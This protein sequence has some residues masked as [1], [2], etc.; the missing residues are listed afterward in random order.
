[1]VWGVF[2]CTKISSISTPDSLSSFLLAA[3]TRPFVPADTSHLAWPPR[4]LWFIGCSTRVTRIS[5]CKT[6]LFTN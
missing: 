4:L 6:S 3:S 1:M 2:Y 5:H